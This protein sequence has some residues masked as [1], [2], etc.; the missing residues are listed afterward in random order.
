LTSAYQN[1][2]KLINYI[3]KNSNFLGCALNGSRFGDKSNSTSL[4]L[5]CLIV[6]LILFSVIYKKLHQSEITKRRLKNLQE[7]S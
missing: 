6:E 5:S 4:D 3:K 2:P 1:D 7:R